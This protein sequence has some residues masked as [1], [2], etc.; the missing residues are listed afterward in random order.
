[1]NELVL[2]QILKEPLPVN[3]IF[4]KIIIFSKFYVI[5][6]HLVTDCFLLSENLIL[7]FKLITDEM[8]LLISWASILNK[9][10]RSSSAG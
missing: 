6:P 5:L 4:F 8:S 3:P 2:Y 10:Y 7:S 9:A 1:M